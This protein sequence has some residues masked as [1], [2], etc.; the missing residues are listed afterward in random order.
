MTTVVNTASEMQVAKELITR[1]LLVSGSTLTGN[2][3]DLRQL[4]P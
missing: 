4:L 1:A 2:S 3:T